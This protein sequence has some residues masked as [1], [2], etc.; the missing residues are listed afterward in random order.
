PEHIR[1]ESEQ[2]YVQRLETE[3]QLVAF[4]ALTGDERVLMIG[5]VAAAYPSP[6][7]T[8]LA[9]LHPIDRD[10]PGGT[11]EIRP[12]DGHVV[13]APVAQID[14]RLLADGF[15]LPDSSGY[16]TALIT[17]ASVRPIE[18]IRGASLVEHGVREIAL[19]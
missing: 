19:A 2:Q 6:D 12:I 11:L 14:H 8:M 4:D 7:G 3:S 15:W 1:G 13:G 18:S 10:W 17:D 9:I 16:I 5:N